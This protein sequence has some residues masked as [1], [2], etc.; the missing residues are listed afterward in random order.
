MAFWSRSLGEVEELG[1]SDATTWL[2][3][4]SYFLVVGV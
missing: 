3:S 2:H 4:T 1:V